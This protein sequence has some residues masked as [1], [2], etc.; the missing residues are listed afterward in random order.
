MLARKSK[1]KYEK[2]NDPIWLEIGFI[3][4]FLQNLRQLIRIYVRGRE[5]EKKGSLAIYFSP[6]PLWG[7]NS[8][9]VFQKAR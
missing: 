2:K 6:Q 1:K 9:L 7:A 4:T 8:E 5:R 3:S